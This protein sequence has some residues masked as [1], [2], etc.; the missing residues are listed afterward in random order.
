[1]ILLD[2]SVIIEI[3]R[4]TDRGKYWKDKLQNQGVCISSPTTFELFLGAELSQK[5]EK[6][7]SAVKKLV[8]EY[9]ILPFS[10]KAS[11]IASQIYAELQKAGKI[12]DL[13]DIYIGA[14][15]IEQGIPVATENTKHF[16]RITRLKLLE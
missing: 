10:T 9:P 8:Q 12:I 6:N 5:R 3:L 13:N 1:M 4:K 14:I 7:Y 16:G 2:T 15:A 11:F